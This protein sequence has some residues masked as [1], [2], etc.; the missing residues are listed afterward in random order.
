ML[1]SRIEKKPKPDEQQPQGPQLCSRIPSGCVSTCK[2][3]QVVRAR[4]EE[5]KP[6]SVPPLFL[7]MS[8]W[9]GIYMY[10]HIHTSAYVCVCILLQLRLI[11]SAYGSGKA[12]L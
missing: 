1:F 7:R 2:Q 12:I 6:I 9:R 8:L 10:V 4:A 3:G 11:H 5:H